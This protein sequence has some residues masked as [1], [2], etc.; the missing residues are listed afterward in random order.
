VD[1]YILKPKLF[2]SA[3]GVSGVSILQST[4][5]LGNMFG[6]LGVLMAIPVAAIVSFAYHEY[7]MKSVCEEKNDTDH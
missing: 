7:F 6:I 3:L 1:A 5:V 4:I 2:S